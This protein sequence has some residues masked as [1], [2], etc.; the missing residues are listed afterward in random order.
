MGGGFGGK[1]NNQQ[2]VEAAT[3]AKAAG[4]PVQVA[5]NR[6]EE[7][8]YDT[9]RPAAIVKI[10]SGVDAAGK[11]VFWDYHVYFAGERGREQFYDIPNHSTVSHGSGWTGG[12]G[13]HPFRT[14][15]WRAPGNNT[16]TFARESQI[17]IMARAA[18]STRSSS[19]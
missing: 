14:G 5:W 16:N 9:F 8:F 3:L 17:D 6:S 13:T 11:I 2:A 12:P 10:R 1:T 15:A 19:A 18:G 7:F 4:C